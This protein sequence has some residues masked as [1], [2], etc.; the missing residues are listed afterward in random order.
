VAYQYVQAL[1]NAEDVAA[2]TGPL[3]HDVTC[4]FCGY[5]LRGLMREGQCPE[6]GSAIVRS[7]A[8]DWLRFSNPD[9]LG[10]IGLGASLLRL[11]ALVGAAYY[12]IYALLWFARYGPP[13][14]L[15]AWEALSGIAVV[16][17]LLAAVGAVYLAAAEPSKGDIPAHAKLRR[18]IRILAAAPVVAAAAVVIG[19]GG[20][21][22][23]TPLRYGLGWVS[24]VAATAG[25]IGSLLQFTLVCAIAPRIPSIMIELRARRIR[26]WYAVTHGLYLA[27]V[28]LPSGTM[29]FGG[30]SLRA[31]VCCF[32]LDAI[33]M[34]LVGL[35][36]FSFY[37]RL[38]WRVVEERRIA[39]R[40][41]S[42]EGSLHSG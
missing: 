18:W 31:P 42:E 38:R 39:I 26:R 17:N 24:V 11:A 5:N 6:C 21:W 27:L 28:L 33:P 9:W 10:R 30:G 16:A 7:L 2:A 20:W 3:D 40:L 8:P 35:A 29:A 15:W 32:I 41:W 4:R 19:W 22:I 34:A 14:I 23:S 13:P 25:F 37:S 12:A 36:S 1:E